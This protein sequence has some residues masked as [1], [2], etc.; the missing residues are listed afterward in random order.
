MN[1]PVEDIATDGIE[2]SD[3]IPS[4]KSDEN[5]RVRHLRVLCA[6]LSFFLQ[7]RCFD[8][9]GQ[10]VYYPTHEVTIFFL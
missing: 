9:G 5:V 8:F 4:T 7:F 2:M 6:Y 1:Y 10:T 3:W